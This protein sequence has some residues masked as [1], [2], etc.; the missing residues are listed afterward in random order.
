MVGETRNPLARTSSFSAPIRRP[1]PACVL[2]KV[3]LRGF[4]NI[5][6]FTPDGLFFAVG[7]GDCQ[8]TLRNVASKQVVETL[9]FGKSPVIASAVSSVVSDGSYTFCVCTGK[10]AVSLYTSGLREG[11]GGGGKKKKQDQAAA[12]PRW[13][14]SEDKNSTNA[15]TFSGN[16][17]ILAVGWVTGDVRIF[18][19]AEG[20]APLQQ[21]S[22]GA[23]AV[24]GGNLEFAAIADRGEVLVGNSPVPAKDQLHKGA[25][26]LWWLE[27]NALAK[28][29]TL[30]F[31]QTVQAVSVSSA[32]EMAVG[33]HGGA[34]HVY[35]SL[36]MDTP[37]RMP[38]F[39]QQKTPVS[40]L[41][42]CKGEPV[43]PWAWAPRA[44]NRTTH[45]PLS[46]RLSRGQF[47][48]KPAV[49]TGRGVQ[50]NWPQAGSQGSSPFGPSRLVRRWRLAVRAGALG[51]ILPPYR[52][53]FLC[54]LTK[55]PV[56]RW[57]C[58]VRSPPPQAAGRGHCG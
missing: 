28:P 52:P 11:G 51:V 34:V 15:A 20:A 46:Y 26:K 40:R 29:R 56:R 54:L 47:R 35:A 31:A 16:G 30:E 3:K 58:A 13:V 50:A 25:V 18:D 6:W 24:N 10:G 53:M 7:G 5:A 8:L 44:S 42:I 39:Q 1:R 55:L 33:T 4:L 22:L 23:S 36:E 32:G 41:A 2:R 49:L 57:Q 27:D 12:V 43:P 19:V 38:L 37:S 21:V 14:Y 17:S 48:G 9:G 45:I